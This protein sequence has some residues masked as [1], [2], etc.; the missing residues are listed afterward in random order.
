[1]SRTFA[2]GFETLYVSKPRATSTPY[3]GGGLSLASQ[4]KDMMFGE[5]LRAELTAGIA[6]AR[7]GTSRWFAQLDLALPF[8]EE[9]SLLDGSRNY[10]PTASMALGVGF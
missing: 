3:N 1:M 8:F 10:R 9:Q 4:S 6:F 5:G 2:F 7:E